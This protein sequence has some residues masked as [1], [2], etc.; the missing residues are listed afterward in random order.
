[1]APPD[2]I[3]GSFGPLE[4]AVMNAVWAAG[5]PVAVRVVV[6]RLNAE[7]AEPLAYT[8]VMT[9]MARLAEKGVLDRQKQGRGFIYEAN[10]PDAA[11]L[12]VKEVLNT[13]GDAAVSHFFD[14]AQADPE[15]MERLRGILRQAD[16]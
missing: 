15:V 13:Y 5:E 9:V 3:T 14:E 10:A 12:A 4:A 8:T 1:M 7:R 6:D 11:G 2:K 16:G